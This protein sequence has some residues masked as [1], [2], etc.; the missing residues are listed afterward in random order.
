MASPILPVLLGL[1]TAV[2]QSHRDEKFGRAVDLPDLE[3]AVEQSHRCEKVSI[4]SARSTCKSQLPPTK[5]LFQL[6]VFA[7]AS[8]LLFGVDLGSIGGGLQSMM[9]D[10]NL[11]VVQEQAVVSGAKGGAIL[12]SL[13]G[14]ALMSTHGRRTA[15]ALAVVPFVIG[16]VLLGLSTSF[17]P[18]LLG[19]LTMGLGIGITAVAAPCYLAE[20]SPKHIRGAMV[21]LYEVALACGFL[22]ASILSWLVEVAGD[23]PGGCWRYQ[24]GLVPLVAAL[25]LLLAIMLVPESP[26]WLLLSPPAKNHDASSR[27]V[28]ALQAMQR[29]GSM[30]AAERIFAAANPSM[31]TV[32]KSTQVGEDEIMDLWEKCHSDAG[33]PLWRHADEAMQASAIFTQ[34]ESYLTAAPE[35]PSVL[36]VLGRTFV[37]AFAIVCCSPVVPRGAL[38]GLLLSVLG[39]VLDQVCAS[40]SVLS[41][42]QHLLKEAG[43]VS[44]VSQ[45]GMAIAVAA[46]KVLGVLLGLSIVNKVD[47]RPLL[48]W[49]GALSAVG[50]IVLSFGSAYKSPEVL[51]AGMCSFILIFVATWGLGYWVIVT[52]VTAVAGPRYGSAC[53]ALATAMLFASGWITSLTFVWIS[54]SGPWSLMVYAGIA[55]LMALYA[56]LLLPETRGCTLEECTEQVKE[57][58]I[59]RWLKKRLGN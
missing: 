46:A 31:G 34:D 51:L 8:G 25:P 12:G 2:E 4:E 9:A 19:R 32:T 37:D 45:D 7:F 35:R 15:V 43:V 14:G 57:M 16:P 47:R 18:A 6:S 11:S 38:R 44:A 20:V 33:S 54:S 28:K 48:G 10:L 40:T 56:A 5:V 50:I 22:L 17:V 24:S 52:E 42:A 29:L 55:V 27:F 53:Q 1:E 41:Y 58:P 3:T 49:G 36:V 13:F 59:E 23:C 39:A 21:A 30:R 26:R